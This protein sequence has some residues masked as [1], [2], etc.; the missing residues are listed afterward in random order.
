MVKAEW[1]ALLA[2]VASFIGLVPQFYQAFKAKDKVKKVKNNKQTNTVQNPIENKQSELTQQTDINQNEPIPPMVR[3]LVFIAA[4][5][6]IGIIEFLIFSFVAHLSGVEVG[7]K[8]MPLF[9]TIIF[10]S[11]FLIPGALL[12]FALTVFSGMFDD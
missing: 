8:T 12:M 10:Y 1:I 2:C 11:L 3:I 6:I 9:W 4:A 5:L 7:I